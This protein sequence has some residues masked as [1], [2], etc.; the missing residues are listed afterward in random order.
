MDTENYDHNK[1]I[2]PM[3]MLSLLF[4]RTFNIASREKDETRKITL[5]KKKTTEKQE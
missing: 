3:P 2:P 1:T 5:S 4:Y